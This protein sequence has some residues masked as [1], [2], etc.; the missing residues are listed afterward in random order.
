MALTISVFELTITKTH[1]RITVAERRLEHDTR[2]RLVALRDRAERAA[3]QVRIGVADQR[4][5]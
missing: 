5:E 1:A 4:R 2:Q 3:S